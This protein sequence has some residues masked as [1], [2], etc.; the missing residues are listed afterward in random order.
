[1][2]LFISAL[3]GCIAFVLLLRAY[4]CQI[5]L[6]DHP[7]GRK[8][9]ASPT[10]AVGGLAMFIALILALNWAHAFSEG[11]ALLLGC[12]GLLV[13]LGVLDDKHDLPV[14]TRLVIQVFLAL[15]VILGAQGT[16]THLGALFG[17]D[18]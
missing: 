12:A 3:L 7:G 17:G 13:T 4:S 18:D 14:K 11:I 10:P 9:H 5:G 6:L 2:L 15:V 1:M 8:Q 16:I